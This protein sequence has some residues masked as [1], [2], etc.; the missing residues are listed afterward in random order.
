D[1]ELGADRQSGG[2]G[3]RSDGGG[4]R[5]DR[6]GRRG[7]KNGRA[8]AAGGSRIV[9]ASNEKRI[10]SAALI[11]EDL[12]PRGRHRV[13]GERANADVATE[14][15]ASRDIGE[16]RGRRGGAEEQ[17]KNGARTDRAGWR[18][19]HVGVAG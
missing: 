12:V 8:P 15:R 19:G 5:G 18:P 4:A 14:V 9:E 10:R 2:H 1:L 7:L 3:R 13:H 6:S 17:A 16:R 11:N